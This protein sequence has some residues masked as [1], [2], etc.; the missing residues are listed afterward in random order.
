MR[1]LLIKMSSMGDVFHTFPALTDAMKNIPDLKVDWI[2]EKTFSEIPA[3]HPVVDHVFSIELRKWRRHPFRFRKEIQQFFQQ[4]NQNDYDLIL[5][6]Q[7]LLKSAWVGRKI[8]G[9]VA[10]LDWRSA[11]ESLA[12]LFYDQKFFVEKHLHAIERLRRLFAQALGYE[13]PSSSPEYHLD[14]ASWR[15]LQVLTEGTPYYVFLHGTTWQTKFWPESCWHDLAVSL[16]QQGKQIVLPWGT[17]EE[18]SRALRI[19]TEVTKV[20]PESRSLIQVPD[21]KLS[22]NEM[23][24]LLKFAEGVVSVDT[25]LSHV[26]A[27]LEVPMVVLYRVTDPQKI[28]AL[29]C[30]VRFLVSPVAHLYLKRFRSGKEEELSMQGLSAND[31]LDVIKGFK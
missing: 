7:G 23:A 19:Q 25:G 6:A 1:I 21:Q 8:H 24:R 4:V 22:L 14:T 11:R 28:G 18:R 20:L 5:D 17:A 12:S 16:A 31:V 30:N 9:P 2:V 26:A 13:A 29:G 3:W 10:G 27:A 15:P